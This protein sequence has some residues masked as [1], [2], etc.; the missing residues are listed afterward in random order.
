MPDS[1]SQFY[2]L[3]PDI[4]LQAVESVGFV[5]TGALLQLN[6]YENRVYEIRL[7]KGLNPPELN[8]RM[9]GKFYRPQRWSKAALLEEHFF[10][11]ELKASGLP[12]IA[13]LAFQQAQTLGCYDGIYFALYPKCLGRIPQELNNN[14]LKSI[15]RCLAHLHNVGEQGQFKA[16]LHLDAATYGWPNLKILKNWVD[17]KSV[18]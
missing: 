12:V 1:P 10:L 4:I 9:I 6:S 13:P 7:E 16:R 11:E 15:G 5:P 8:E 17:R 3:T 2:A 18:V 14:Q